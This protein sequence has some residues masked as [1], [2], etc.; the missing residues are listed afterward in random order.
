MKLTANDIKFIDSY[1]TNSG[2]K[3]IDIRMEMVDHI[4][5]ALEE[6]D[7]PFYETFKRYMAANKSQFLSTNKKF[8]NAAIGTSL[9]SIGKEMMGPW[10][11]VPLLLMLGGLYFVQPMTDEVTEW[12]QGTNVVCFTFFIIYFRFTKSSGRNLFSVTDRL[13]FWGWLFMYVGGGI[14]MHG[15]FENEY[16]FAGSAFLLSFSIALLR[17]FHK[18]MS[19]YK[20]QYNG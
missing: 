17:V 2:V 15:R 16:K 18:I 6:T 7:G 4:A 1:L 10:F 12:T 5:T 9:K 11:L 8:T 19:K 3:Y 13:L 20:L 14:L